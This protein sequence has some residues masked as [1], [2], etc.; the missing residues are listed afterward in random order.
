MSTDNVLKHIFAI[1]ILIVFVVLSSMKNL[2]VHRYI[3]FLHFVI[4]QII[5]MELA[6]IYNPLLRNYQFSSFKVYKKYFLSCLH[7]YSFIHTWKYVFVFIT[8]PHLIAIKL[9]CLKEKVN[10]HFTDLH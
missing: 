8:Y 9:L 5:C 10:S 7:Y 2:F 6:Q 4:L 1:I 3:L